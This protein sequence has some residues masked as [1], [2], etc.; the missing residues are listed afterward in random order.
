MTD[1]SR[2]ENNP[3]SLIHFNWLGFKNVKGALIKDGFDGEI[4][5]YDGNFWYCKDNKAIKKI[6][7]NKDIDEIYL[8]QKYNR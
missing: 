1:F 5:F 8:S 2:T 3:I 4:Q 7:I 6:V